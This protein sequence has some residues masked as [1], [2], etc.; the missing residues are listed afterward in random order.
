METVNYPDLHIGPLNEHAPD[1][2]K[3]V[4]GKL[5]NYWVSAGTALGLYRDKDFIPGDTDL[6]FA[7]IGYDGVMADIMD[8]FFNNFQGWKLGRTIIDEGRIM[9]LCLVKDEVLVDLYFHYAEGDN[10]VNYSESGK[11]TMPKE[12]Y[13][14]LEIRETKYGKVSFVKDIEKYLT[15]RYGND[16]AIPQNKKPRFEFAKGFPKV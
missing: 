2:F 11:Q 1:I 9:Q 4:S 13:D 14:N 7:M 15:I 5:K 10:Y 16:W 3:E 8:S 12:I 6:D